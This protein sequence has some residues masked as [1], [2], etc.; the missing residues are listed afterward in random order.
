MHLVP[1]LRT[2]CEVQGIGADHLAHVGATHLL[3]KFCAAANEIL[4][5]KREVYRKL[6]RS[7]TTTWPNPITSGSRPI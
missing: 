5:T 4:D 6:T 3:G 1:M 7:R 2:L